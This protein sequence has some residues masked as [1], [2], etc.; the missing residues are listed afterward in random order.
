MCSDQVIHVLQTWDPQ[1]YLLLISPPP[2]YMHVICTHYAHE[3]ECF[4]LLS[5]SLKGGIKVCVSTL[6]V[7][8]SSSV[9]SSL[10]QVF[11]FT[12]QA[13]TSL[14]IEVENSEVE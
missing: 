8:L 7:L 5:E 12:D 13:P 11:I 10:I 6:S 14:L 1:P 3:N 4:Y 2:V 9:K